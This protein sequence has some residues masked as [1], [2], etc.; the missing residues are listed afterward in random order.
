MDLDQTVRYVDTREYIKALETII[1]DYKAIKI[2]VSGNSMSPFLIPKRDYVIVQ[3]PNRPLK[4]GDI[5]L[6]QRSNGAYILHR[7]SRI[8][9]DDYY[10]IGDAQTAIEGPI[11]REQI[12]GIVVKAQRKGIWID[13]NDHWWR[14]FQRVWIRIIPLRPFL[15]NM[16]GIISA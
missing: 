7:I 14:F 15:R 8:R 3:L 4:K 16:Y 5:V 13:E 1:Q 10:V 12:F 11:Q 2:P 6:F 9:K